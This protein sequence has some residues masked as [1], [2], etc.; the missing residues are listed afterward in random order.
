MTLPAGFRAFA[1]RDFRLFWAGQLVSLV[2]TWM[3][4]VAQAWLVLELTNSPFRLGLIGTL[5]FTPMLLLSFFAGA[6]AD[7]VPKRRLILVTQSVLLVQ[8]LLLAVLVWHGHVEYWHVAVMATLYGIANTVDMPAR[9]A[10]IVEMVGKE[11]LRSAIALNSGMFNGARIVGPAV[12]GLLIAHWGIAFAFLAN[13]LSFVA[14]IGALLAVRAEGLPHA[15]HHRTLREDIGEGIAYAVRTPRITLVLSLVLAVSGF[16]FN[17]NV[18]VPLLARD[19]LNQGARGFG[20][21]MSLLGMGAVA[22]AVALGAR[23]GHPSVP[24]LVVP[25]LALGAATIGLAAVRDVRVAGALLVVMGFSGLLFMAG[26]HTTLQL[27]VPDELRGRVMS[28]HTLM[29]AGVTPF[30]AFLVG[31]ITAA[32]GVPAGFAITGTCGMVAVL[33]L[34][35]WW[36]AGG[37]A[38]RTGTP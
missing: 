1:H 2:G 30:G 20:L 38:A 21:L 25:A 27:T 4:S 33:A 10:F 32:F 24:S 18:L 5:Q 19:V 7:R 35:A 17:Y 37:R 36:R 22:G 29:F 12:A 3:Q 15:H 16:L 6:L 31:S 26:A 13:A 28:L 8:A 11:D 34:F 14:V 23:R 9:Q